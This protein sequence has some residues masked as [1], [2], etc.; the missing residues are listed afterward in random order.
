MTSAAP[1]F[2]FRFRKTVGIQIRDTNFHT[3]TSEPD[4]GRKA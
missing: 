4:G 3:E 2:G 1:Q